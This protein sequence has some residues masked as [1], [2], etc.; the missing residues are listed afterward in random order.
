MELLFNN[1]GLNDRAS[2]VSDIGT[3]LSR[4]KQLL[5]DRGYNANRMVHK[6]R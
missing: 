6:V 3:E 1:V 4:T 2:A 5:Q